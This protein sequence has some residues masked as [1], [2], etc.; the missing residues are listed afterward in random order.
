MWQS[1]LANTEPIVSGVDEIRICQD[2]RT[3]VQFLHDGIYKVVNSLKSL[4]PS[5]VVFVIALN[6]ASIE[7]DF[8]PATTARLFAKGTPELRVPLIGLCS[9]V[10]G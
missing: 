7:L 10:R 8:Q 3:I 2:V 4:H 9:W 5:T 1:I 6:Y